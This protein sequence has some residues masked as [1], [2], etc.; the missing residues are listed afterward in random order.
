ML[1]GKPVTP[2]KTSDSSARGAQTVH[3]A[4]NILEL[5]SASRPSIAL[6]EISNTTG[7]TLPT[8]H[9][10][11]RALQENGLIVQDPH[12]K[13]YSLGPAIARMAAVMQGRD[14]VII[15]AHPFMER[16]RELSGESVGFH[17]LV[18]SERVCVH[19]LVSVQPLRMA[20][21]VGHS[22]P[23]IA[24]AGGKAILAGLSTAALESILDESKVPNRAVIHRSLDSVRK[25][26]YATSQGETVEGAAAIAV[27]ICRTYGEVIGAI[28]VTG[29]AQRLTMTRLEQLHVPVVEAAQNLMTL[30]GRTAPVK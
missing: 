12:T 25:L 8:A 16:L 30:L 24:G 20:S 11:V 21:G 9:R 14:D 3:R 27:A 13:F 18:G 4:M 10:L 29:P 15:A 26:G 5:F 22:Y 23:L 17:W 2:K 7:L 6:A 28:N 1:M 19:E